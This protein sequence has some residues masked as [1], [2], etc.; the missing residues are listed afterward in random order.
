MGWTVVLCVV[1]IATVAAGPLTK[2]L[3]STPGPPGVPK[4]SQ[5]RPETTRSSQRRP[6]LGSTE[7]LPPQ[8]LDAT[9]RYPPAPLMPRALRI[10]ERKTLRLSTFRRSEVWVTLIAVG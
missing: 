7:R 1:T 3:E 6:T 9:W 2:Q 4:S 5:K 10:P 8:L